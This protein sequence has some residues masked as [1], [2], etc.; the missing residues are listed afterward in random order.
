MPARNIVRVAG[1]RPAFAKLALRIVRY[2]HG[3]R[4][5]DHE[6]SVSC[7]RPASPV[8]S[9]G[10]IDLAGK[11]AMANLAPFPVFGNG[12]VLIFVL[13]HAFDGEYPVPSATSPFVI[14][15]EIGG[16]GGAGRD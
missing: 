9:G 4:A 10:W 15:D 11:V 1:Y 12:S 6:L 8:V 3:R 13:C 2:G 14:Y 5:D 16:S 7:C